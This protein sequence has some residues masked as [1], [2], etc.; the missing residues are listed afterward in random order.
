[1]KILYKQTEPDTLLESVGVLRCCLKDIQLTRDMK[2]T[3]RREHYH[4]SFE[5]H[6]VVAGKKTYRFAG[7]EHCIR[8]GRYLMIPPGMKHCVVDG[9]TD[10][11][12]FSVTFDCAAGSP[13]AGVGE[14]LTGDT[15]PQVTENLQFIRSQG[16]QMGVYTKSVVGARLFE[17]LIL[18]LRQWGLEATAPVEQS[19]EDARLTMAKQYIRDNIAWNPQVSDVA[20]YCY[21][22]T[23]QLTRLFLKGEDMAPTAYIQG[24]RTKTLEY[25]LEHTTL[26]LSQISEKMHF[27]SENYLNAYFKKHVGISPGAYRKMVK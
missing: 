24:C 17:S 22:S 10:M 14:A 25:L 27:S 2:N 9:T 15:D 6:M 21:L 12:K 26:T 18:L 20:Q 4:T 7:E 19:A 23:K 3:S 5:L 1:M 16:K 13:F 11:V 8:S